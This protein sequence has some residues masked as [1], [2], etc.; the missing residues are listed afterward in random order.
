MIDIEGCPKELEALAEPAHLAL[1]SELAGS[2]LSYEQRS[3]FTIICCSKGDDVGH[4]R[5]ITVK[6][7]GSS[8]QSKSLGNIVKIQRGSYLSR[9]C[10]VFGILKGTLKLITWLVLVAKDKTLLG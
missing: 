8:P 1:N 10:W 9:Q 3:I 7:R 4:T 6:G 5:Q 2:S